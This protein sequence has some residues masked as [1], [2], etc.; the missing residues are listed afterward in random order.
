[1][2][3]TRP[4][5]LAV[6]SALGLALAAGAASAQQAFPTTESQARLSQRSYIQ[7]DYNVDYRAD[8]IEQ[9]AYAEAPAPG[10][11]NPQAQS[12]LESQYGSEPVF[13]YDQ[14]FVN[15]FGYAHGEENTMAM[16]Y[17]GVDNAGA[18]GQGGI[19]KKLI[20]SEQIAVQ[21][22]D[23]NATT[24]TGDISQTGRPIGA[25]LYGDLVDV[26]L[27]VA[28]QVGVQVGNRN[29]LELNLTTEQSDQ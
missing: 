21:R 7:G 10:A 11:I 1:M 6:L 27:D 19:D 3:R 22:G 24:L 8:T 20:I 13:S 25:G 26:N 9:T 14:S 18:G 4:T 29:D 23:G 17:S 16:T 12:F 15:Q 2:T 5:I 28:T